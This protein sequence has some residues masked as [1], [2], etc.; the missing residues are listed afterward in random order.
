ML[1]HSKEL[2]SFAPVTAVF[3]KNSSAIY[4]ASHQFLEIEMCCRES[5][6]LTKCWQDPTCQTHFLSGYQS[7][8]LTVHLLDCLVPESL[9]WSNAHEPPLSSGC[10]GSPACPG[11]VLCTLFHAVVRGLVLF[12]LT[13]KKKLLKMETLLTITNCLSVHCSKVCIVLTS[14]RIT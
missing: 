5:S 14:R 6:I 10:P 12:H 7:G 4:L 3:W 13:K 1:I 11:W 9:P 2:Y 8:L